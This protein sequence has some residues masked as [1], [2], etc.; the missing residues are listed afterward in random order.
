MRARRRGRPHRRA[1][2]QQPPPPRVRSGWR[3]WRSGRSSHS[4]L[5]ATSFVRRRRP[6]AEA[7]PAASCWLL[8]GTASDAE[9]ARGAA[10]GRMRAERWL[11]VGRSA[12][13]G[14]PPPAE[15]SDRLVRRHRQRAL[16]GRAGVGVGCDAPSSVAAESLAGFRC[17]TVS[18]SAPKTTAERAHRAGLRSAT[19]G[20]VRSSSSCG[21]LA[22][23]SEGESLIHGFGVGS[24]TRTGMCRV[25][26]GV[27]LDTRSPVPR[28]HSESGEWARR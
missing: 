8:A 25:E 3:G 22:V 6:S 20:L 1:T 26:S 4:R 23:G 19:R 21:A 7:E 15:P 12:A 9:C 10:A 17:R 5:V 2:R 18:A 28:C 13:R 24:V 14:S 16:D 27:N 11:S